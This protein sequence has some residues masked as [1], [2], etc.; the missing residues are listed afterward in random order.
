MDMDMDSDNGTGL[1]CWVTIWQVN[2]L[3]CVGL[4]WLGQDRPDRAGL[5]PVELGWL[6]PTQWKKWKMLQKRKANLARDQPIF[7]FFFLGLKE[8]GDTEKSRRAHNFRRLKIFSL[9]D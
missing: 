4:G 6:R 5:G 8:R 2:R 1:K 3:G 9:A 7:F